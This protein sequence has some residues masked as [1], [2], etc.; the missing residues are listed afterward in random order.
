MDRYPSLTCQTRVQKSQRDGAGIRDIEAF[1]RARHIE[2]HQ[3]SQ[4][5]RLRRRRPLPSPPSTSAIGRRHGDFRQTR[6]RFQIKA[7]AQIADVAQM[8]ERTG[9]IN[10]A[11]DRDMFE[12]AGGRFRQRRPPF[13]VR[14]ARVMTKA[15]TPKAAAVRRIAPTLCGSVI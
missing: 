3:K 9:E 10:D 4:F 7:E 5:S 8:F 13:P 12:T 1:D 6:F 11:D 15:S 2:P 14:G